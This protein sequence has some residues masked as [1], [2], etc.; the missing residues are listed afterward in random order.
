MFLRIFGEM[1]RNVCKDKVFVNY[2]GVCF[3][4]LVCLC[5]VEDK[6]SYVWLR[7]LILKIK[8]LR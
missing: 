8:L 5:V 2:L 3:L 7:K 1:R 4:V 6:F